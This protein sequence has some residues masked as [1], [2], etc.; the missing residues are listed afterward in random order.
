MSEPFRDFYLNVYRNILKTGTA[1][2]HD[3]ECSSPEAY[4]IFH[5]TAYPLH[6]LEG[7]LV[8]S[9]LLLEKEHADTERCSMPPI[10]QRYRLPNGLNH[11]V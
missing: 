3:Y 7:I 8:V 4:R 9:S 11:P 1:W 10:E 5:E 6:D 2:E